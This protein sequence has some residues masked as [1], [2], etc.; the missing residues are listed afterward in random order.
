MKRVFADTSFFYCLVDQGEGHFHTLAK[1]WLSAHR[2]AARLYSS[3]YIFDEL[4]TLFGV[5]LGKEKAIELAGKLRSSAHI[6]WH[7]LS[8]SEEEAAWK[9]FCHFADK[10]WSFTD[11]TSHILM[12]TMGIDSVLT[13]DHHFK[14]MGFTLPFD[15]P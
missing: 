2:D 14:Q 4:S 7:H 10:E 3:N 11:C 13:W 5:R 9:L 1:A 12:K 8:E 6:V 15:T